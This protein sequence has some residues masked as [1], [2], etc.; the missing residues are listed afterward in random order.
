MRL[1]CRL[2]KWK[3]EPLKCW[4]ILFYYFYYI[5]RISLEQLGIDGQ[6]YEPTRQMQGK[7]LTT[8]DICLNSEQQKIPPNQAIDGIYITY[9]IWKSAGSGTW[10]HT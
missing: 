1:A 7:F 3:E 9:E 8:L 5:E 10:T 4:R 6:K 2:C